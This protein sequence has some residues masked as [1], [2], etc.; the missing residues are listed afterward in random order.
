MMMMMLKV[1]SR[2]LGGRGPIVELPC[3]GVGHNQLNIAVFRLNTKWKFKNKK[4]TFIFGLPCW[5]FWMNGNKNIN[6]QKFL[7]KLFV[8]S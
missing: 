1:Q 5:S 7:N 8:R 4:I 6:L 3:C 2:L